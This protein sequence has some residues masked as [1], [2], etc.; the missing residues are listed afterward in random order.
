VFRIPIFEFQQSSIGNQQ[1]AIVARLLSA[2]ATP[3]WYR[4]TMRAGLR[5][6]EEDADLFGDLRTQSVLDSASMLVHHIAADGEGVMKQPLGQPVAADSLVRARLPEA[7]QKELAGFETDKSLLRH[8]KEGGPVRHEFRQVLGTHPTLSRVF[9]GM[10][11]GL[12]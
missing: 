11:D 12:E 5:V 9:L 6:L 2:A 8:A 10:P 3:R 4:G 1:L 7:G